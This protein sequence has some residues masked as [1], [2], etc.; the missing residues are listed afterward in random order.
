MIPPP[1]LPPSSQLG[2]G[3]TQ[4]A[5]V[6]RVANSLVLEFSM[7]G[8]GSWDTELIFAM[9]GSSSEDYW[10][11]DAGLRDPQLVELYDAAIA[12]FAELDRL[13]PGK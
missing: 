10:H 11:Y 7:G 9:E 4:P 3:A 12:S 5:S 6:A 8:V 2:G 13:D 1:V